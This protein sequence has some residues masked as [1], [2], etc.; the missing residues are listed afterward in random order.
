MAEGLR[1]ADRQ[2]LG[3]KILEQ[4]EMAAARED[5]LSER[6]Q[7]HRLR[8][9]LYFPL[10]NMDG[11]LKE[12]EKALSLA[13]EAGSA[14]SEALAHSGLGDAYYL[15]G[16][17]R[18]SCEQFRACVA[19]CH[20]H[21]YGRI[22]V[23]NR[24]MVGWTRMYLM[25]FHEAL[26]DALAAVE[27][28]AEVSHQRAETLG[29]MLAGFV[30]LELGRF[31]DARNHLEH[32]LDLARTLGAGNFEANL[33]YLLAHLEHAQGRLEQARDVAQ[34]GIAVIRDVGVTFMGP[35][36]L[37]VWAAVTDDADE[38]R[39]ALAEAEAIMDTGCV[40]HNYLRFAL[41]AIDLSLTEGAWAEVD[42]Y[43]DR[44]E[45]STREQA[46]PWPD[47][48]I[49][50]GR[51]LAAWGRGERK[52]DLVTEIRR[53]HDLAINHGLGLAAPGLESALAEV[54]GGRLGL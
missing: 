12:H 11:C 28:A 15:R 1:V 34:Q 42:R 25:E 10:G 2:E 20:E 21:G 7:I 5:L 45:L 18:S 54:Q 41:T 47:F 22:E 39:K 3:L 13:R 40:A 30:E 38:R 26:E 32:G 36:V 24:H 19:L 9:N 50:R 4:A 16:H 8:G 14:E 31:A 53:L 51:A 17:M 44:L 43:A 6:A 52:N 33:L 46:L 48:V 49:A 29:L 35:S 27:M 23:A 37:S